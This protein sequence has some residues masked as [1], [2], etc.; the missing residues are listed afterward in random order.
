MER[1]F[2]ATMEL[3]YAN[4]F[5]EFDTLGMISLRAQAEIITSNKTWGSA[6]L[7]FYGSVNGEVFHE[8][9]NTKTL[10]AAGI[11]SA[12]LDITGTKQVRVVVG[13]ASSTTGAIV[14][15]FI[16]AVNPYR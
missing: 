3:D 11:L 6:V 14:Q 4:K 15:V 13:T 9:D 2:K 1:E 10:S 8:I 12:A 7:R 5:V 16:R